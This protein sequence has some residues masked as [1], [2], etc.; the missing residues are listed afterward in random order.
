ME[1]VLTSQPGD[2]QRLLAA[3]EAFVRQHHLPAAVRQAADL[4]LEEHLTNIARYAYEDPLVHQ[5]MVRLDLSEGY[6]LV[7]VEDDGKPF[8]PLQM[9]EVDTSIPLDVKPV[10]GLG[11]HLIRHFMDDVKYRREGE[12]NVLS[13]RKRLDAPP[14]L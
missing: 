14:D 2:K 7:E 6:L 13:M 1:I 3:L 10:G 8:N 4:A 12:R 11:I 5:I 9:A